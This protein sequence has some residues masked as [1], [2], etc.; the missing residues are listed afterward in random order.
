LQERVLWA[1]RLFKHEFRF[2]ADAPFE[3]IFETT[4]AELIRDGHVAATDAELLPGSGEG[5]WSGQEWL[6]MYSAIVHVFFEGYLIAAKSL[7]GLLSGGSTEKE[8]V[9][10]CLSL[11]NELSNTGKIEK[12]EAVSKPL[13]QNAFHALTELGYLRSS[14]GKWELKEAF[15]SQSAL[16][17]LAAVIA[18][19]L[20][21]KHEATP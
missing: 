13:F 5:G 20:I 6:D 17:E 9:K 1:S 4:L 2:R 16:D 18:G 12:P 15:H 19:Y 7:Q 10:T 14:A 8:L 3:E 21:G 11:G